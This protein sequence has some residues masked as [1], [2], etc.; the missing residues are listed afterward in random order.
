MEFGPDGDL[1]VTTGKHQGVVRFDGETGAPLGVFAAADALAAAKGP[2]DS[3]GLPDD[4]L[5]L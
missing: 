5:S 4:I 1:Y 2:D 3:D